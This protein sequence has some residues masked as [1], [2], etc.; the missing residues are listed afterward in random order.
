MSRHHTFVDI[1]PGVVRE[2]RKGI[3]SLQVCV[4]GKDHREY[5]HSLSESEYAA[6]APSTTIVQKSSD[7]GVTARCGYNSL[8]VSDVKK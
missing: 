6:P 4:Q 3:P 1:F 2:R 5:L 8:Q 7:V